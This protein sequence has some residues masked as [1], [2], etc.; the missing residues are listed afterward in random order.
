MIEIELS[1]KF[2]AMYQREKSMLDFLVT[3]EVPKR[4]L[5]RRYEL[6]LMDGLSK[7]EDLTVEVKNELVKECRQTKLKFTN[8]S[9]TEAARILHVLKFIN[10]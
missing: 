6:L 10:Q 3:S 2:A 7:I 4:V 8:K 9:L 1:A 5:L